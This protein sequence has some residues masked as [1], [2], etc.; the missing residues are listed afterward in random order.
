[1]TPFAEGY[2]TINPMEEGQEHP[3]GGQKLP[4]RNPQT[5]AAHRRSFFWQVVLPFSIFV[6][7][8]LAMTALVG[9][10]AASGSG[11][12]R[13]W[14]DA[15]LIFQLP[16]PMLLSLLCLGFNIALLYGLTRLIGVIPGAARWMHL[17][18]LRA[19]ARTSALTER[20]VAPIL[21]ARAAQAKIR[22]ALRLLKGK[23]RPAQA[24]I[25]KGEATGYGRE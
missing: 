8:F 22:A 18:L 12:L 14:A 1:M 24:A 19:Q 2:A 17:F 13:R 11:A 15:A 7:L 23:P 4:P 10:A 6:L 5:Y 20:L 25:Q 3:G 21:G 16:L 9:W